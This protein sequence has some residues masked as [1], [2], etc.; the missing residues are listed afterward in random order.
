MF[1]GNSCRAGEPI[2]T[3]CLRFVTGVNPLLGFSA[4][5]SI[6]SAVDVS[7][8]HLYPLDDK[9]GVSRCN[10]CVFSNLCFKLTL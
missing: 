1:G 6:H 7:L 2:K 3:C 5:P 4:S 9:P 8:R 10:S